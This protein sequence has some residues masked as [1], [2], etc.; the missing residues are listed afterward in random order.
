MD[1]KNMILVFKGN[2]NFTKN[3]ELIWTGLLPLRQERRVFV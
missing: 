2:L 1:S 3:Y